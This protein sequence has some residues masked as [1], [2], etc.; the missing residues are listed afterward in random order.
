MG[1]ALKAEGEASLKLS[2]T[3]KDIMNKLKFKFH[4]D[5]IIDPPPR[6]FEDAVKVYE[7]LPTKSK[8]DER[9]VSFSVAPLSDYCDTTGNYS[10]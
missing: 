6:T 10:D 8:E 4:G 2:Q 3:E 9:V 5:T 7:S 1:G